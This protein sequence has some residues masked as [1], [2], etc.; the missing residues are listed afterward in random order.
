V[1][2]AGVLK[3]YVTTLYGVIVPDLSSAPAISIQAPGG[4]DD[5][6]AP[7]KLSKPA[8]VSN[9]STSLLHLSV[10]SLQRV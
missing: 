5:W 10:A 2:G 7:C 4:M 3:T 1:S 8:T 9:L 6:K